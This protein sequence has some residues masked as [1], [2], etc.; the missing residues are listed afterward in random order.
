MLKLVHDRDAGTVDIA[1]VEDLDRIGSECIEQKREPVVL[2][3]GRAAAEDDCVDALAQDRRPAIFVH[4]V[5]HVEVGVEVLRHEHA[6]VLPAPWR[7][8][9]EV[10]LRKRTVTND[11]LHTEGTKK[12][13]AVRAILEELLVASHLVGELAAGDVSREHSVLEDGVHRLDLMLEEHIGLWM[14]EQPSVHP[15]PLIELDDL[16]PDLCVGLAAPAHIGNLAQVARVGRLRRKRTLRRRRLFLLQS[17]FFLCLNGCIAVDAQSLVSLCLFSSCLLGFCL[18]LRLEHGCCLD[19]CFCLLQRHLF[20]RLFGGILPC[21][22]DAVGA[23]APLARC[24]GSL[25]C[26]CCLGLLCLFRL[27]CSLCLRL[28]CSSFCLPAR[29]AAGLLRCLFL[30]LYIVCLGSIGWAFGPFSLRHGLLRPAPAGPLRLRLLFRSLLLRCSFGL[31]LCHGYCNAFRCDRFAFGNDAFF[32]VSLCRLF[33]GLFGRLGI[34]SL[35]QLVLD[36]KDIVL[37]IPDQDFGADA[38]L[39]LAV[40][41]PDLRK[42]LLEAFP[43]RAVVLETHERACKAR[44]QIALGRRDQRR[45]LITHE[46]HEGMLDISQFSCHF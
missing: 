19:R 7:M 16:L 25:I 46:L 2:D 40:V 21:L 29:A 18:A 43:V 3:D 37:S 11:V 15:E 13:E 33:F 9:D 42:K 39:R 24:L 28:C 36:A 1:P 30:L 22:H 6:H 23:A 38:V 14:R 17:R 41:E 10:R 27:F 8:V 35:D 44:S 31:R 45:H 26:R 32:P 4:E 5:V 34:G 12:T 20:R